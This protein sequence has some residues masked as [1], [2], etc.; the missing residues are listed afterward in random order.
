MLTV[1]GGGGF[2]RSAHSAEPT[3]NACGLVVWFFGVLVVGVCITIPGLAVDG[4]SDC[5]EILLGF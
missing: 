1:N 4:R 5:L 2:N 3:P